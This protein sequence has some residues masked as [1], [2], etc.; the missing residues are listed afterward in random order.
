MTISAVRTAKVDIPIA[1]RVDTVGGWDQSQSLL[2]WIDH[3]DGTT[4][5]SHIWMVGPHNLDAYEGAVRSLQ[6]HL[7]DKDIDE[8]DAIDRI[9]LAM[10]NDLRYQLGTAGPGVSAASALEWTLWDLRG[11]REGRSVSAMLG[12]VRDTVPINAGGSLWWGASIDQLRDGAES[13][14]AES[15][16][17]SLDRAT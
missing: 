1:Q 8:T 2:V 10:W 4:G 15:D 7:V 6:R 14:T 11:K 13:R 12:R 5:I 16:W 17:I 9:R 3:D